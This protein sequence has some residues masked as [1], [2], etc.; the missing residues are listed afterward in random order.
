MN[1]MT[2]FVPLQPA[3]I[4]ISGAVQS[5]LQMQGMRQQNAMRQS[6]MDEESRRM[7]FEKKKPLIQKYSR[8]AY[9]LQRQYL[10]LEK[11][12]G[13]DK[14]IEL[15]QPIYSPIAQSAKQEGLPA[16]DVFN[17]E[18][19][20]RD[21]SVAEQNGLL[22]SVAKMDTGK[23]KTLPYKVGELHD[24]VQGKK[25]Y[26]A[27]FAGMDE[28]NRPIW[29][30]M[31]EKPDKP[32]ASDAAYERELA[33]GTAKDEL[34]MKRA[35]PKARDTNAA[36]DKQWS[37][38][39]TQIDKAMKEVSP[40]TTGAGSWLSNV[41]GTPQ[42]NLKETLST[43]KAN[44]GFDKLQDMRQNSPTGGALGQVSDMENRLLQ[45][46]QGSLDQAQSPAQ[47]KENLSNIKQMLRELRDYKTKAFQED[48]AKFLPKGFTPKFGA[49]K[50][51]SSSTSRYSKYGIVE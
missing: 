10:Q 14:A 24:I 19:N 43:I 18:K 31:Q 44:I 4:D 32:S 9:E 38:V 41:P 39:E 22:E 51:D 25:V 27:T 16:D 17:P 1:A 8:I 26:Q 23:S 21:I 6:A 37:F 47:M 20:A 35:F 11:Q 48:Y 28:K 40:Y 5:G 2:P 29:E 34:S 42:K 7:E 36:L 13:R 12:H 49:G 15:M 33:K 45:A 30:N 50:Q 46:V 3:Q